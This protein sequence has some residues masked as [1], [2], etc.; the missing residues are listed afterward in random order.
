MENYFMTIAVKIVKYQT[1]CLWW[2]YLY[3]CMDGCIQTKAWVLKMQK[4][5]LYRVGGISGGSFDKTCWYIVIIKRKKLT[6]KWSNEQTRKERRK[7]RKNKSFNLE[8]YRPKV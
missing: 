1:V 8:I 6:G 2:Q 4:S 3:Q 5:K 7:G